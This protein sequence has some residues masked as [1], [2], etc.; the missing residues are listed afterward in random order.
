MWN[1]ALILVVCMLILAYS[2][3]LSLDVPGVAGIGKVVLICMI[4]VQQVSGSQCGTGCP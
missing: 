1:I 3:L 4:S 2:H